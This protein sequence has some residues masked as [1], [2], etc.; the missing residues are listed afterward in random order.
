[1]ITMTAPLQKPTP[2]QVRAACA[3]Y[4]HDNQL[5][6][7]ALAELL[8]QYPNNTDLRHVLLKVVAVNS[9]EH[10]HIFALEAVARH[11][12]SDIPELDRDL[13]AGSPDAVHKIAK[14]DIQGKHYNLYS[15][16]TKYCSR[17]N[18]TAYPIYD[19]RIEHYLCQVQQLDRFS[20][21]SHGDICNYPKFL[22][23]M[24]S[25]RDFHGLGSFSF[26][27]IGKFM[28]LQAEPPALP[29]QEE[30]QT[31][32]GTFDFFPAQEALS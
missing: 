24:N 2:E 28:H 3:R 15:F 18:P 13:A 19:Q 20:P 17:H 7:Q 29:L 1:M 14:V 30:I 23:V 9:L 25:F 21:F 16:A 26:A 4:D 22:A 27:E 11:I 5:T 31:G 12:L 10:T 32:P 6:E 8:R